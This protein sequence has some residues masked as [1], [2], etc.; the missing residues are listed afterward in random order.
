MGDAGAVN[1]AN[2]D[3]VADLRQLASDYRRA[4][5]VLMRGARRARAA[6]QYEV[7]ATADR[8]RPVAAKKAQ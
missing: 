2:R 5:A 6:H 7:A 3:L 8:N 4:A 1:A